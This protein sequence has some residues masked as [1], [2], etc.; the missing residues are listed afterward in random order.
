MG[1]IW[2]GPTRNPIEPARSKRMS[3]L[4]PTSPQIDLKKQPLMAKPSPMD[5]HICPVSPK[6]PLFK[7]L[8]FPTATSITLKSA[9]RHPENQPLSIETFVLDLPLKWHQRLY[10]MR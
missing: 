3:A 8:R 9:F 10:Q 7:S 2:G 6:P 5:H 1:A 4:F